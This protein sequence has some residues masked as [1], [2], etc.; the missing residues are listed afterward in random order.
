M[1]E[2]LYF[3]PILLI[4]LIDVYIF[5]MIYLL[6]YIKLII[7]LSFSPKRIY[8]YGNYSELVFLLRYYCIR[9]L[10][11]CL[12]CLYREKNTTRHDVLSMLLYWSCHQLYKW[13][14]EHATVLIMQQT[15][16][17]MQPYC[18]L[19]CYTHRLYYTH[20]YIYIYTYLYICV[21]I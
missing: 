19:L 17:Y 15:V 2:A 16:L 8:I 12:C 4:L 7:V 14:T 9:S 10:F 21:Y 3:F 11:T 1:P 18:K 5:L 20:L 6:S 13:R